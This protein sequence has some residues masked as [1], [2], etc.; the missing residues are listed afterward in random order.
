MRIVAFAYACEP[1]VGSEPGAGWVW[2]R[3]LASFA[4]VWV[5]TRANNRSAIEA[6]LPSTPEKDALTFVYVDLPE[7]ARIGHRGP[8]GVRRYYQLWQ[9]AALREARR[10]AKQIRPNLVWHLTLANAW[11]GS[12]APLAGT[13]F[14]YG[15][16]GG[17]PSPP[18]RMLRGAPP[19]AIAFELARAALR[20]VG[21]YGNPLARLGWAR[22]S[23]VLA[24]NEETRAW[25]PA[26]HR[27]KTVVFPNAVLEDGLVRP[28]PRASRDSAR[29]AL[30]AG[31]LVYWKGAHLALR[32]IAEVEGWRLVVCGA[33]PEEERLRRLAARL[34][35]EDRV[36]FRGWMPR[37]DLI[38]LMSEADALLFPSLHD[39]APLTVAEALGCGL[40]PITLA[41]GGPPTLAGPAGIAV[42]PTT[43]EEAVSAIARALSSDRL[44]RRQVAL[45]RATAL[46]QEAR[47][48]ELRALVEAL[49]AV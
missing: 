8:R 16:V 44:P 24:Q 6:A 18:W 28:A 43:P 47:A 35:V 20:T 7:W 31:R 40:P 32:A 13:R 9:A 12:L 38:D 27:Q 3:M 34:G 37:S 10:L 42:A 5:V 1:G 30:Y 45:E 41:L 11:L 14:V 22:A 36:V 19:R 21:R 29:T 15:P 17:G 23:L 39:D 48:R 2:A 33:G 46:S 4:E 49:G 26:R 25:L